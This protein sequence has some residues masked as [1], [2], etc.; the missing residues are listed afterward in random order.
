MATQYNIYS[1]I[2]GINGFGLPF[3]DTIYT[4]TLAANTV[5]TITVPG[6]AAMGAVG[7]TTDKYVAIFSYTA[8]IWVAVNATAAI[9]AG[10]T[11]ALSTSELN[12][13]AKYVR[14]GD[15]I[16]IISVPGASVSVSIYSIQEG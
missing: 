6:T 12:P 1:Y 16:S 9:P 8:A 5:Q 3:C 13:N 7:Y 4:A 14:A 2:K 11:F 15:V 10:G